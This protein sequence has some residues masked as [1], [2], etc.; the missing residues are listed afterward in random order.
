MK[1]YKYLKNNIKKDEKFNNANQDKRKSY[2]KNLNFIS[3]SLF[4]S[5]SLF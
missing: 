4:F 5:L 1:I 2:S 3:S